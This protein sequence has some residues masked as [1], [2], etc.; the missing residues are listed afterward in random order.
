MRILPPVT[1]PWQ[2]VIVRRHN[3]K[4]L[5]GAKGFQSY[6]PCLRWEFG[7]SCAFCLCHEADLASY[8]IQGSGLTH[9]EHFVPKSRDRAGRNIYNNCFYACRF[10]NVSRGI[11]LNEGAEGKLINPCERAWQDAF[12]LSEDKI[13]PCDERD[14]DAVYTLDTYRLNDVPKVKMRRLRRLAIRRRIADYEE[15]QTFER[16][17]LDLAVAGGGVRAARMAKAISKLRW[18]AYMDLWKFR[19]IPDRHDTSCLC[20]HTRHHN[21]PAVLEEQMIDISDLRPARRGAPHLKDAVEDS[22]TN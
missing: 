1:Q 4:L 15:T 8:P 5:R 17:L 3:P 7:F 14:R 11:A 10:C 12:V 16:D 19:G 13:W 9:V 2:R 22:E 6:R 21:L 20:G 18:N